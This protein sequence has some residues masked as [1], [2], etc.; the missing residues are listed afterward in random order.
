[1]KILAIAIIQVLCVCNFII[2]QT[3][4]QPPIQQ[5]NPSKAFNPKALIGKPFPL[6]KL[7]SI[8]NKIIT[9]DQLKGKPTLINFWFTTCMPCI[10][11]MPAL[12]N[13]KSTMKDSVNF[14]AITHEN[15]KTVKSFLKK[16]PYT[17]TQITNSSFFID[18]LYMQTF[19]VNMFLDKNGVITKIDGGIPFIINANNELQMSDGKEFMAILRKLI[20]Q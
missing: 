4:L 19:P 15:N 13:I 7:S 18:S 12:N 3:K 10:A 9:L 6:S 16:H 14:I 5:Q 11:E 8:N 2:A 17:F 20:V 1:M